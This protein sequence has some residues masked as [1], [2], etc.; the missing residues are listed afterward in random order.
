VPGRIGADRLQHHPAS[1]RARGGTE[2]A[3]RGVD[4]LDAPVSGREAGAQ[5]GTLSIMIGGRAEVF[6]RMKP[7]LSLLG[8][9]LVTSANPAPAGGEGGEPV[10][11]VVS[12]PGHRRSD[13]FA[14]ATAWSSAGVGSAHQRL[15]P[16]GGC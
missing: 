15:C 5:A 11:A 16:A 3:G 8:K 9:T 7:L 12:D 4:L 1:Y 2:L 14:R 6:E 10:G 13:D